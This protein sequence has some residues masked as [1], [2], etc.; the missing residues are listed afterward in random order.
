MINRAYLVALSLLFQTC[1]HS[2]EE[3]RERKQAADHQ[4]TTSKDQTSNDKKAPTSVNQ[5]RQIAFFDLV[6]SV[7]APYIELKDLGIRRGVREA[8]ETFMYFPYDNHKFASCPMIG[9]GINTVYCEGALRQLGPD[10]AKKARLLICNPA[11][12]IP[13]QLCK[14]VFYIHPNDRPVPNEGVPLLSDNYPGKITAPDPRM[15]G[16][17]KFKA[18]LEEEFSKGW[19]PGSLTQ[20][21]SADEFLARTKPQ[22]LDYLENPKVKLKDSRVQDLHLRRLIAQA[23]EA[24]AKDLDVKLYG[25]GHAALVKVEKI[26]LSFEKD[27]PLSVDKSAKLAKSAARTVL[28]V[29]NKN[30]RIRPFLVHHPFTVRDISISIIFTGEKEG[31]FAAPP[32]ASSV[33]VHGGEVIVTQY[34][35]IAKRLRISH[36]KKC[37]VR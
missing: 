7:K 37:R 2:E 3:P 26:S 33:R 18:K 35:E 32:S 31:S 11:T 19:R 24:V 9:Y 16:H 25:S 1:V 21:M 29:I 4:L 23:A 22:V 20:A 34:D 6:N 13:E 10:Y 27:M 14:E 28:S 5:P 15:M 17:P 30:E 8:R 12:Y 36:R